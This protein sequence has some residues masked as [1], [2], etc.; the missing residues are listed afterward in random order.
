VAKP[1][2]YL[3]KKE[4]KWEWTEKEENA[5][6]GLKTLLTTAPLLQQFDPDRQVVIEMD[7]LNYICTGILSQV[8]K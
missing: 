6:K 7:A 1:L 2:Y 3:T 5:F 4:K 8:D